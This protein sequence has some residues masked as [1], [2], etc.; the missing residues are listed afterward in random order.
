[1]LGSKSIR[2]SMMSVVSVIWS[3]QKI[4]VG[5]AQQVL[6]LLMRL[7]ASVVCNELEES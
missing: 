6:E 5:D 3:L 7:V 2:M 4:G 1:M